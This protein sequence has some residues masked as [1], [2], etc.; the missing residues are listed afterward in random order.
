MMPILMLAVFAQIILT[1]YLLF[2]TAFRRV[3]AVKSDLSLVK[4]GALDADAWPEKPRQFANCYGNQF[5]LPMLFYVVIILYLISGG[6]VSTGGIVMTILAWTFVATRIVHML[7]HTG[8]NNVRHR[9]YAF[10][11]GATALLAMW[12]TYAVHYF[13]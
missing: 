8:T 4:R 11:A 3:N 1:F 12:V 7:I 9:F 10:A 13:L 2:S 5:E 6:G